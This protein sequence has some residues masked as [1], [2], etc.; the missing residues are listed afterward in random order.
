MTMKTMKSSMLGA[1]AVA[2]M[3]LS[4]SAF[5]Q[6]PGATV[7]GHVLNPAG[8]DFSSGDVMERTKQRA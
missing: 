5:A 1:A 3:A 4:G 8:Q 7:H 2:V 6:A